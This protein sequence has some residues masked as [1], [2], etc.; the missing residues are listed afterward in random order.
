MKT[1]SKKN[2]NLPFVSIVITVKNEEKRIKETLE[3]LMRIDYPCYEVILVDGGSSDHTV[4]IAKNY[5]IKI[6]QEN[7]STPSRGRNIGIKKSSGEIIAFTDGD[8]V[9]ER[10]WLKNAVD[11]F[12]YQDVGGVG[13][14]VVPYEGS[15]YL[16]RTILSVL[17]SFFA[18]A[19][20]TNFYRYAKQIEVKNIPSCNAIYRREV[21]EKADLFPEDLRYCED[22]YL[23]HKI[24]RKGYRIIYSPD[25]VV[26]HNWK[27]DSF[28]S[29]FQ[30]MLRYG[31]GR[32]IAG[33]KYHHL[34]S[35]LHVI[36]SISL[37]LLLSFLIM[38]IYISFFGLLV[39][40]LVFSYFILVLLFASFCSYRLKEAK[41][42]ILA[43]ITYVITHMGYALGFILGLVLK[44]NL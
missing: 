35:P 21:L 8:C 37:I 27:V 36:P 17:S 26:K 5:P 31:A 20:S 2:G 13:G 29:L 40:A 44:R 18:S 16:S 19:G 30:F 15:S 22:V 12:K 25:V 23:N 34:I 43:S 11:L 6:F 32:A 1:Y 38:S 9:V 28:T 42:F 3:S 33:R 4:D 41:V 14:P 39:R 24:R 7:N 10:S